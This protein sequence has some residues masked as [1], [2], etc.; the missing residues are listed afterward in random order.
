MGLF[1]HDKAQ[2][3]RLDALET[4]VRQLTEDVHQN[5]L[6]VAAQRLDLMKVQGA[7]GEKLSTAEVD[8]D[9]VDL[10]AQLVEARRQQEEAEAAASESW[11]TLQSGARESYAT[12]RTA[13]EEAAARLRQD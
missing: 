6:D 1:G 4:H 10:N 5:R 13:I 11:D 7:V 12:L 8:Q 3:V 2:N 9:L